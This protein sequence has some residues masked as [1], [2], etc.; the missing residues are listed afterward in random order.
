MLGSWV[1]RKFQEEVRDAMVSGKD[2]IV[3]AVTGGGKTLSLLLGDN[4]F[5]GLYPNNTL[6]LDQQRS[7]ERILKLA[8]GASL[9]YSTRIDST[10][11]L[12]VYE[13]N[14]KRGELPISGFKRIAVVLLVGRYI[15]YEYDAEGRLVPKRLVIIRNIIEKLQNERDTYVITLGT[16]DTA[17]LIMAGIYRSFEKAGYAI[18]DAILGSAEGVEIEWM[19]SKYGVAT[20]KELGDL[21]TVRQYLLKYPWFVDEFHLYGDYEASLLLPVIRIFKEQVGWDY[22]LIFSSAT[23]SN[24]IYER[25]VKDMK[26][27][28]IK[29]GMK[30][31]GSRDALV[32][33]KTEVE[34]VAVPSRGR[35]IAKWLNTGFEVARVVEGRMDEVKETVESGGSV[36]IVVDRVNQ[37]P[38]IADVLNAHGIKPECSVSIIPSNC[39]SGEERVV[40]GSE[41][42]SQG[43]DR[44]NVK[45]GVIST[46]NAVSLI[47]R[48]GR[49]GRKIDSKVILVVPEMR[50][51]LPIENLDGKEVSYND[52]IEVVKE[53]YNGS[54]FSELL[55]AGRAIEEFYTKRSKLVEIVTT[56]GYAQASKPRQTLEELS[57]TLRDEA[58]LLNL[59]YGRAEIIAKVLMFRGGG[60][61]VL[62]EKPDG[63]RE[64]ADAGVALRNFPVEEARVEKIETDG[65]EKNMLLFK[66]DLEPGR[67]VLAMK[68]EVASRIREG[69]LQR[70]DKT[71]T[72][73]GELAGLGYSLS[74]SRVGEDGGELIITLPSSEVLMIPDVKEQTIAVLNLPSEL[75]EF[76]TYTVQGVEIRAG[77]KS[78]L[79]LFI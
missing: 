62:V 12:R 24:T 7:L 68:P 27:R 70:F 1:L 26:P 32:R 75:L 47:Q 39:S 58:E 15:G 44:I 54:V 46:Y 38:T 28:E 34:V 35:G 56:I 22:P 67:S 37:V 79:G 50:E 13:I 23:P 55:K 40:V 65:V 18:H 25:V 51:N 42:I 14:A 2:V 8:L 41:S 4:G 69:A 30:E 48:F 53:T 29:A 17:L 71:I 49:I 20:V 52:F 59:F 31:S 60:F 19:L 6:L 5:V 72:T 10:D 45:L 74:I 73:I 36:F 9:I 57:K 11:V 76:Y 63:E 64:I 78:M 3:S 77:G 61:P 16:P 66:I 21:A 43:I 33:G